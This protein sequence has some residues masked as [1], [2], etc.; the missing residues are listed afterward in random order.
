MNADKRCK[1]IRKIKISTASAH[2]TLHF[3]DVLD[4]AN[5]NWD[6]YADKGYVNHKREE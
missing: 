4:P 3:E 2:D 5:T 1:L 6:I